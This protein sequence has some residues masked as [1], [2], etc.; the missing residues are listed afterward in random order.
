MREAAAA[1]GRGDP[2]KGRARGIPTPRVVLMRP[3]PN[4]LAVHI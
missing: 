3:G 1:R 4:P 2:M